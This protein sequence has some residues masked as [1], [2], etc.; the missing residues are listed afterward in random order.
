MNNDEY[1]IKLKEDKLVYDYAG[2]HSQGFYYDYVFGSALLNQYVFEQSLQPMLTNIFDGFN[3]TCMAY[4]ITGAGK[5]YTMLGNTMNS[6]LGTK[7]VK[8][9]SELAMDYIFEFIK[10]DSNKTLARGKETNTF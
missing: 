10:R 5:T 9:I 7:Q 8:G 2:K 3:V 4:G 6:A 1:S